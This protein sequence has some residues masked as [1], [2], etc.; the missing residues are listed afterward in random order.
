MRLYFESKIFKKFI[1][2]FNYYEI[3][4]L[5]TKQLKLNHFLLKT[6]SN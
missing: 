1:I 4:K 5:K 3:K 6:H 2:N